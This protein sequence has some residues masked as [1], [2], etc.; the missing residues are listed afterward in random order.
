MSLH[1]SLRQNPFELVVEELYVL[2]T[3][4]SKSR[5]IGAKLAS[6]FGIVRFALKA[7]AVAV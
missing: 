2:K 7:A 6:D 5:D 3:Q 1:L 4:G